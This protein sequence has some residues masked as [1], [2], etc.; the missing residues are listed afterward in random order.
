MDEISGFEAVGWATQ[1]ASGLYKNC[2]N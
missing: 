1:R 2:A